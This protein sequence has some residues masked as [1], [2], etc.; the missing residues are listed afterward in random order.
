MR[1]PI[2][3][4]DP[5]RVTRAARAT[6]VAVTIAASWFVAGAWIAPVLQARGSSSGAWLHLAYAPLC[7]QQPERSLGLAG[8]PLAVCARCTGLYLGGLA[9]LVAG[10]LLLRWRDRWPQRTWLFATAAPTAIDAVLPWLGLRQLDEIPRLL[11]A[12][13]FGAVAGWFLAVGVAG[14][15][16]APARFGPANVTWGSRPMEEKD[17]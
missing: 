10:V 2:P 14:L 5:P 11:L 7:H 12:L 16:E 9:G 6:V 4:T 13:P 8:F 15:F 1:A 3:P 17:A